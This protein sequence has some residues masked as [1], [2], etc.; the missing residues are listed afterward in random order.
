M[1]ILTPLAAPAA[2]PGSGTA[3]YGPERIRLVGGLAGVLGPLLLIAYFL[4]P[5]LVGWPGLA[6]GEAGIVAYAAG[7]SMLFYLGGWLQVTGALASIVLFLALVRLADATAGLPGSAVIVGAALL[8]AV[9]CVEAAFL[10]TVPMAV[11]S[12]DPAAAS[13]TFLLANGVF[14][15]IFPL[16]PAPLVFAGIGIVLRGCRVLPRPFAPAALTVAAGFVLAGILAVF[17]EIG[18]VLATVMSVVEA[19]WV[20]AA[21]I[22]LLASRRAR[23]P[24]T[25][26][27]EQEGPDREHC[28]P[29]DRSR[30]PRRTR[31]SATTR[32]AT[33]QH[34]A[35]AADQEGSL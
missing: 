31:G 1:E 5:L 6:A 35:P 32:M 9:V 27:T 29:V 19:I 13:T 3:R 20:A 10:E 4:T 21:A 30:E 28:P 17:T 8:L 11:A 2:E 34:T 25:A 26:L 14:V 16:A 22:A 23:R 12:G 7:H 24:R 33:A 15:R 18:V